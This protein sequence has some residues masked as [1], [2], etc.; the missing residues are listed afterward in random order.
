MQS[1]QFPLVAVCDGERSFVIGIKYLY[2]GRVV[3]AEVG[4]VVFCFR[5]G[6]VPD[7]PKKRYARMIPS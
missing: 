7:L 6:A 2:I 3:L 4:G 1:L 5:V